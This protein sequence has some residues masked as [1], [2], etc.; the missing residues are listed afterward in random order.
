AGYKPSISFECG[1][2]SHINLEL[3]GIFCVIRTHQ[4]TTTSIHGI[5]NVVSEGIFNNVNVARN[6][7]N[8][9]LFNLSHRSSYT[10][11]DIDILD[12]YRTIANIGI[13]KQPPSHTKLVEIDITKAY[14]AAF[15]KIN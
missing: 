14:T 12:D 3:N 2:I 13:I 7:F 8:M 10:R 15:I 4:L 11:Q 1:R 6:N 5:I 9:R